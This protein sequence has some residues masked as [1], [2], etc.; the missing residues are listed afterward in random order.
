MSTFINVIKLDII[1]FKYVNNYMLCHLLLTY[2]KY[3]GIILS[4]V[5]KTYVFNREDG[6]GYYR[7]SD[8][9]QP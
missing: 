6:I 5:A 7:F 2:R 8:N 3:H 9:R 1:G 4:V